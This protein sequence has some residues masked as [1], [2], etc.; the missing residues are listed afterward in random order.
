MVA[1][2]SLLGI[3]V[4]LAVAIFAYAHFLKSGSEQKALDLE[5]AQAGVSE[6]T[7]DGFIRLRDRLTSSSMV[8][9]QHVM[10]TQFF[11]SLEELT[12]QGV[13]F[14]SLE[15][16]VS[17]DHGAEVAMTGVAKNFNA[18]AGQSAAFAAERRI[19]QAIFA[20][21]TADR[22]GVVTFGVTAKLDPSFVNIQ[23]SVPA[24]WSP[25]SPPVPEPVAAPAAT[26]TAASSTPTAAPQIIPAA[27]P[28]PPSTL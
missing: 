13:R 8:L 10:L 19:K 7:V 5:A 12:L 9:N 21:I 26:T 6:E 22:N 27:G 18:L 15:I 16:V 24:A 14:T 1:A 2:S 23:G 17:D 20:D 28:T 25:Q 3:A 11:D 4:L